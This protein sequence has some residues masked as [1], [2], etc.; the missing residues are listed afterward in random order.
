MGGIAADFSLFPCAANRPRATN[1][2]LKPGATIAM[3][4]S[5]PHEKDIYSLHKFR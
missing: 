1:A 3:V 2:R 5:Q 4:C